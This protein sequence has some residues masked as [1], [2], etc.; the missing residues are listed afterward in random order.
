[1]LISALS[2]KAPTTQLGPGEAWA[3]RSELLLRG[4]VVLLGDSELAGV[5]T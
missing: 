5:S 3:G 1:M 2:P 4:S